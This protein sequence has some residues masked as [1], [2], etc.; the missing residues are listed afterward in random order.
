[1]TGD[2][3]AWGIGFGAHLLQNIDAGSLSLRLRP[4]LGFA[5]VSESNNTNLIPSE[6]A[7]A[8]TGYF[9]IS[10][11]VD[12]GA[13]FQ[14]EGSRFAWFTGVGLQLLDFN[15]AARSDSEL[16]QARR[17]AWTFDGMRWDESRTAGQN[18]LGIGMTFTPAPNV[19]IGAGLTSLLD[20]FFVI[21]LA[22]MQARSGNWFG[23]NRQNSLSQAGAI[24]D[25]LSFDLTVSARLGGRAAQAQ[26]GE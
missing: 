19:V 5:F 26:P 21:D 6:L 17:S 10:A 12:A 4:E 11:R 13:R 20:Q 7:Y 25:G 23:V 22:N 1:V 2:G 15:R 16:E 3:G 9:N 8:R 18:T 24:F 14:A